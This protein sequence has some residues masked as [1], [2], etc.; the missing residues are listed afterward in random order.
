MNVMNVQQAGEAC[1]VSEKKYRVL[2]VATHPTQ[3]SAPAYQRLARDPRVEIQ[4]A[5]C[6]LQGASAGFDPGFGREVEWDIPLLEGYPWAQLP[7]RSPRP[8]LERFGGLVNTGLW[9]LIRRGQFDAVIFYTGYRYATFWLGLLA[10]KASRTAVLFGTD[11]AT[12]DSRDGRAWKRRVKRLLWPLLFRLADVAIVP[13]TTGMNL[14]RS[15]GFPENR[16]ALTP[17]VVDNQRWE[18]AA[19]RTNRTAVRSGWAIPADASVIVFSAKLQPWKRPLDLVRAFARAAVPGSYLLLA[20]EGPLRPAI[21]KEVEQL[22]LKDRVKMLGFVNQSAL[23]EVYRAADVLVLPSDYEPFGVVVNEAMLCG[24]VPIVS[25]KVGARLDLV[26]AGSTGFVFP[27]GDVERLASLLSGLLGD[28]ARLRR[29]SEAARQ[30]V[31][32][33][34]PQLGVDRL[35]QAIGMARNVAAGNHPGR[36]AAERCFRAPS[37]ES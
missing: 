16:V 28:T 1:A 17:Y 7:N 2:L 33:W 26:D 6:S 35:L 14:M 29:I 30:R 27:V 18:E 8:G 15:L 23:P 31:A 21:E 20:G 3:Y 13:S 34:S 32:D 11:A 10:A 9:K 37:G 22:G 12:L 24:C 25:D 19:A 5:Y 36:R 4:V